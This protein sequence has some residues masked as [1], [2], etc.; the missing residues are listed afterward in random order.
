MAAAGGHAAP[1]RCLGK[2]PLSRAEGETDQNAGK[3]NNKEGHWYVVEMNV[4]ERKATVRVGTG[5]D[6]ALGESKRVHAAA[7]A[8]KA[9]ARLAHEQSHPACSGGRPRCLAEGALASQEL[10]HSPGRIH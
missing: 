2:T 9:V 8:P 4:A 5:A 1:P 10:Q 6:G 3:K 7:A